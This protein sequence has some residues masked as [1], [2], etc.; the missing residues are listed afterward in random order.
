MTYKSINLPSAIFSSRWLI[1]S[2]W[3][4][5][6]SNFFSF[7]LDLNHNYNN[8]ICCRLFFTLLLLSL[9]RRSNQELLQQGII[10]YLHWLKNHALIF[11]FLVVSVLHWHLINHEPP[12]V[13]IF[14][15]PLSFQFLDC[16]RCSCSNCRVAIFCKSLQT[17]A[18][19]MVSHYDW[20][21]YLTETNEKGKAKE[22]PNTCK[23]P[24]PAFPRV[25]IDDAEDNAFAKAF[26]C[27]RIS[28]LKVE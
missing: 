6:H 14:D 3:I 9:I 15:L 27:S 10:V 5:Q 20:N 7:S 11:V 23:A 28:E 4:E 25:Q 17:E 16:S 2:T 19:I 1:Y 21:V 22:G 26:L 13:S 12:T 8:Q 18:I 24:M